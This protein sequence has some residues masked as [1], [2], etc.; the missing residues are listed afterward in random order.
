MLEII[1]NN[2]PTDIAAK[3]GKKISSLSFFNTSAQDLIILNVFEILVPNPPEI[4]P[5]LY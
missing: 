4:I 3:I 2:K 5:I 1:K